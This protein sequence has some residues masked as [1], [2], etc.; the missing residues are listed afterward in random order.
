MLNQGASSTYAGEAE[1]PFAL[2][3]GDLMAAL[4]LIFILLLANTILKL[5]E[6]AEKPKEV[7]RDL[8]E[9]L[10]KE[11]KGFKVDPQTGAV[12][13]P[14]KILFKYGEDDLLTTGR[15]VLRNLIPRYAK[16][17]FSSDERRKHIAQV[18]IEGH[19]DPFGSYSRNL[20]LSL[21]RAYEVS[22]Y[23]FSDNFVEGFTDTEHGKLFWERLTVNGRSYMD[24]V[25]KGNQDAIKVKHVGEPLDEVKQKNSP[26]RRVEFKF[27]LKDWEMQDESEKSR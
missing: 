6:A 10:K 7:K 23:I 11:L 25:Y 3:L 2:S 20:K 26:N 17:L 15:S 8:I 19:T 14:E 13:L 24:L 12:T 1:N 18:I 22:R 5:E 16:V 4:L 9:E 21:D 27:R